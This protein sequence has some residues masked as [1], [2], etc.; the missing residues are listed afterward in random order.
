[1]LSSIYLP[2]FTVAFIGCVLATPMATQFATWVGAIDRPD[3]FRRLHK[4][5]TPRMGGLALAL[6][7]VLSIWLVVA[8]GYLRAWPGFTEWWAKQWGV[9]LAMA[10]VLL[11]GSYDDACGVG[12]RL[13]L[14]GQT[15]AVLILF[16]G[17]TRIESIAL[18]GWDIPLHRPGLVLP[19]PTGPV[20]VGLPS[21]L[22]TLVWFLGCMNIWN[23]IDGMDGLASGVGLVVTA[24]LMVI[25]I[26]Q[27]NLGA[28]IMAAA[29]AG[30]L[31]GFLLYNW[32]PACIFLGDSGSMLIGLLIGVIGVQYSLKKSSAVSI[33]FPI[34]AMGLPITDTAI[35]IFRR[36]VR[37]LPLT[38]AD[39]RHIHHLLIGLGLGPR[40]AAILLYFLTGFFCLV[41]LLGV[42]SNNELIA[43]ITGLS[44][45]LAFLL[46]LASRR[47][48]FAGLWS[49]FLT[50]MA[51][52]R[53]ERFA[54]QVTWEAIQRI[55][56]CDR[57]DGIWA[58]LVE[59]ITKLGC[60]AVRMFCARDGRTIIDRAFEEDAGTEPRVGVSGPA[61]TF[62]LTSGR[63]LQ[64]SVSLHQSGESPLA[65]DIAFRF[66]QRLALATAERL[67]R[68]LAAETPCAGSGQFEARS[69]PNLPGDPRGKEGPSSADSAREE[70]ALVASLNP[71]PSVWT[72]LG[73]LR[74]AWD[75]GNRPGP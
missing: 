36:W 61:A 71:A 2:V 18:M 34:L 50:R 47:D 43:L 45:C 67:E 16:L 27:G 31:A 53:Q 70:T 24:T 32:H 57:V 25:A 63:D 6:G 35:A 73:W 52:G 22:V 13:K 29:L 19:W 28:A 14:L 38:A 30:S 10:T 26:H 74:A 9:A 5:A 69:A 46:I 8:W 42:F 44:G 65:A 66:L 11:V 41:T 51:R 54:A 72:P 4:A 40:K 39:R 37:D 17:G 58:I 75:A 64:L 1:M 33:L 3:Q 59:T 12:P 49:D 62:R 21:L 60:D 15:V 23:L 20:E 48:E 56:L 7:L 68:L 55:E